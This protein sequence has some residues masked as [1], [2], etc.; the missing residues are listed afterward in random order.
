MTAPC[1]RAAV[2]RLFLQ[3][4]GDNVRIDGFPFSRQQFKQRRTELFKQA[5][6]MAFPDQQRRP[7]QRE[8]SPALVH[9]RLFHV[10]FRPVIEK[11]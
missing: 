11:S 5:R 4:F 7:D 2:K 9:Q 1:P 3:R 6:R 10:P 8:Q